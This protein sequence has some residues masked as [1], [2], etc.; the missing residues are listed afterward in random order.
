[1]IGPDAQEF[2]HRLTTVHVRALQVGQ[3]EAGCF[4]SA[5]G[6]IRAHFLLWRYG[7]QE[8][9]FEIDSGADQGA[10]Q[11]LLAIIDQFTFGEKFALKEVTE[12]ECRW[13]FA[14]SPEE[15][16][17]LL[18]SVGAGT[19]ETGQTSAIEE[20]L[21][22]CHHGAREFGRSMIS[23]WGRPARLAQ[24][25]DR[26]GAQ[27]APAAEPELEAWRISALTPAYPYEINENVIPLEAGLTDAIADQ[28]GCY[29]G[30]E[31]IE[32][33][34]ALGAPA[35]R[36][37]LLE[38]E[39]PAP[40]RGNKIFNLA[41]PPIE[42]GVVTSAASTQGGRFVSLAFVRKLQAKEGTD[43]RFDS[44]ASGKITQVAP[45]STRESTE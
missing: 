44:G 35:R 2:L 20:E 5:Q 23:V 19:L 31:V 15:E 11:G 25:I 3:G 1:M 16:Q 29:P 17:S 45:Y 28:K 39:G 9:G 43:V 36:L 34:V 26:L 22:L 27:L 37:S 42:I 40:A 13:L 21:R 7:D 38:G 32:R 12:L 41:E 33:I 24:W 4:L 6:K 10:K 30:Q 18:D 14:D 8:F